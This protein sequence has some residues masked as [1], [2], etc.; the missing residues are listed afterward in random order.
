VNPSLPNQAPAA[1]APPGP[2]PA[3]W[4][5]EEVHVHD[6]QL[7]SYLKG[8]FP[9]VRDVEDVVQESYLRIWKRQALRPVDSTKSF[10][11]TIA[12]NL[13]INFLRREKGSPIAF[14]GDLT[15]LS[16]LDDG[17]HVAERLSDREK[18]ELL[19]VALAALPPKRRAILFLHK[20]EGL[21]QA[22]VAGKFGI[23][24]KAVERHVAKALQSCTEFLRRKGHEFF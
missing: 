14:E 19:G 13:A 10:L 6:G 9:S 24:P 2:D 16:V 8:A 1:G 5:K 18:I 11:F 3:I 4:F 23:T 21:P 7:K 20:F 22:E 12:R 17:A 15:S